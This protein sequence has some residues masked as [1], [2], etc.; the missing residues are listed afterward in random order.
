MKTVWKTHEANIRLQEKFSNELG[1]TPLFAQILLN[2]DIRTVE[3]AQEFL[4]LGLDACPDPFIMK[5]MDRGV[6]RVKKAIENKEK[7]LIYGDYDVDG[8]TSTAILAKTMESL[9]AD[10]ETFIP[11][12]LE[13]GYGLNIRAVARARD[14]GVK[15]IITVDCGINSVKEVEC[16]NDY[17][18]DVI[19]T[20]HHEVKDDQRPLA[21]AT[22]DPHQ[23]ECE[24]PFNFLAGVGVAYKF[25]RALMKGRENEVDDHLDLVALGTIADVVLLKGENRI[26]AKS[27]L[28][29]LRN[30]T[31]PG[32][33]ALMEI[34][35]VNP[36]R[37]T[38]RQIGFALAPRINA[39]GRVGSANVALDLLMCT[40][41]SEARE[42]A[43]TLD[44]ENRN[45][46][47][48]QADIVKDALAKAKE[49]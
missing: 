6:D 11:N 7:I 23:P 2:R 8:V 39:M 5:D 3:E 15:L 46:Q 43:C 47:K 44:R 1:I 17:G 14:H 22:I 48:I 26:L 41:E 31:K 29:K 32:I 42:L 19:I 37:L 13:D 25:A 24:Y 38:C 18:I 49:E 28:K 9:G 45:R 40:D 16:A 10:F 12:R 35:Y 30:T 4:F 34:A 33:K 36:E 27:G 20:D 21:Y